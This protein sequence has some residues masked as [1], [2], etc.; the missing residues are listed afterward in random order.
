MPHHITPLETDKLFH[1]DFKDE[2]P[3]H[4]LTKGHLF[5]FQRLDSLEH[6]GALV[7]VETSLR[8]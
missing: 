3:G 4:Q 7:I 1:A 2:K 5:S 8:L 6:Q